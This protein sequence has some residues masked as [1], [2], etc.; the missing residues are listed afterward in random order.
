MTYS[1]SALG[2]EED[3]AGLLDGDIFLGGL[4]RI[5]KTNATNHCQ[6]EVEPQVG[7]QRVEAMLYAVQKVNKDH[8]ILPNVI[9]GAEIRD[10]CSSKT[11]A[12]DE[13]L[14]FIVESLPS[15]P[16]ALNNEQCWRNYTKKLVGVIGPSRST[17]SIE[18]AKLLRLFK[19]P[20]VSY[21][22]TSAELSNE[23]YSYFARTVPS[24]AVQ[25]RA[26]IDVVI[27]FGWKSVFTINS[28]GSYGENG[29]N[30]FNKEVKKTLSAIC[31]VH[32][33]QVSDE[34]TMDEYK[35]IINKFARFPSTR[36][37]ILFL[38]DNHVKMLLKVA[39]E[40]G[41]IGNVWIASDEWGTRLDIVENM[42]DFFKQSEAITFKI[43]SSPLK[44]FKEHFCSLNESR[45]SRQNPWFQQYL[46]QRG[47]ATCDDA[48]NDKLPFVMDAVEVFARALDII[49]KRKC[50]KL[51]GLCDDM[52][53]IKGKELRDLIFNNTFTGNSSREI[54]I[55]K[56]GDSVGSYE[57]FHYSDKN[58][59]RK[60]GEWLGQLRLSNSPA[61]FRNSIKSDCSDNCYPW[62]RKILKMGTTCCTRCVDCPNKD[63]QYVGKY[64]AFIV[65]F[66]LPSIITI[67]LI[68]EKL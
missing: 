43:T 3:T 4:F 6:Q 52:R 66:L 58:K 47:K 1:K 31:V 64:I 40:S 51:R 20:Q 46:L 59:Y 15:R 14:K 10:T 45:H 50:P 41:Y 42:E 61:K 24:D 38:K 12:L 57:I 36:V 44:G 7:I 35:S 11:K 30:E 34:S 48:F 28:A 67:F 39:K 22:S 16:N 26:M 65:L 53:R 63:W 29:I 49:Y 33:Q 19:V 37:I 62:S 54:S 17:L 55:R 18:V 25:V 13:S 23:K 2:Q 5:R 32:S 60:I 27:K 68:L 9:L 21:A 56:N 8:T